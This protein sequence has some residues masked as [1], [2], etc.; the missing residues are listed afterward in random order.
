VTELTE[1]AA[2]PVLT[3][4]QNFRA[5]IARGDLKRVRELGLVTASSA[6]VAS[7]CSF[8]W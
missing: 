4:S 5:N 8:H 1:S 6:R 7:C 2:R 3:P